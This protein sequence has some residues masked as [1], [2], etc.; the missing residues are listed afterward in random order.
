[1]YLF[2]VTRVILSSSINYEYNSPRVPRSSSDT[3][4]KQIF[5]DILA[6]FFFLFY[7]E[8]VCCV[9]SLK[10]PHRDD[11]NEYT[12]HTIII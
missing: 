3:S 7:H 4:R 9:Y 11:P 5:T 8:N 1:M 2:I 10:P 12:Q 6:F